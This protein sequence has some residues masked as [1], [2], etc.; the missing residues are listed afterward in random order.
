MFADGG[1]AGKGGHSS[2]AAWRRRPFFRFLLSDVALAWICSIAV[3]CTLGSDCFHASFVVIDCVICL[4]SLVSLSTLGTG[5]ATLGDG[6]VGDVVGVEVGDS[7]ST[8]L[9]NSCSSRLPSLFVL[10]FQAAMQSAIAFMSLS[11]WAIVEL[12]MGL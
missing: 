11:T 1:S 7:I 6:C 2:F 10:P 3:I 12:V 5:W 4:V 9:S 8:S